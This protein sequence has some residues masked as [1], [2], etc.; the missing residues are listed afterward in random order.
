[1]YEGEKWSFVRQQ[2]Y[3]IMVTIPNSHFIFSKHSIGQYQLLLVVVEPISFKIM[4]GFGWYGSIWKRCLLI[5]I[6]RPLAINISTGHLKLLSVHVCFA[7]YSYVLR[8]CSYLRDRNPRN[9]SRTG[10]LMSV[11]YLIVGLNFHSIFQ[12]INNQLTCS[13]F[14]RLPN[15]TKKEIGFEL[16]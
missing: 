4:Y 13:R 16:I 3:D 7:F 6:V 1:M 5:S 9:I 14:I 2:L 12:A 15:T 8:L 11:S 10:I